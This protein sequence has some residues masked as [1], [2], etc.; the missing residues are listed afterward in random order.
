MGRLKIHTTNHYEKIPT[1]ADNIGNVGILKDRLIVITDVFASTRI[2][3][4]G[5]RY[6][7]GVHELEVYLNGQYLRCQTLISGVLYGDYIEYSN[8]SVRFEP[9][10]INEG[11]LVRFRV[12][13]ANYRAGGLPGESSLLQEQVDQNTHDI[14]ENS[15]DIET[16]TLNISQLGK[17][18]FGDEY[19]PNGTGLPSA[20]TIG[21]MINNQMTPDLTRYRT[22]KTATGGSPVNIVN[23][24]NC[25]ADDVKYI[26]FS[27][28]LTTIV[29]NGLIK[30]QGGLNFN[31]NQNDTIQLIFD[32]LRWYELTRS[33]NS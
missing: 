33:L 5:F 26:I 14:T 4:T 16:N 31:G 3:P 6:N 17:E 11:D 12:T 8:F 32:G 27:N 23:F 20:R 21:T 9:G 13:T 18:S 2:V 1:A 25:R 28:S 22:W 30:L 15:D 10:T 29:S 19:V 24:I 7:Q